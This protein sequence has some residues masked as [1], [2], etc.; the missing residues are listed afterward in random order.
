MGDPFAQVR[1]LQQG[2]SR[3]RH[4]PPLTARPSPELFLHVPGDSGALFPLAVKPPGKALIA[5]LVYE[6]LGLGGKVFNEARTVKVCTPSQSPAPSSLAMRHYTEATYKFKCHEFHLRAGFWFIPR[7]SHF[8]KAI[9]A[10]QGS[11]ELVSGL[12]HAFGERCPG[13]GEGPGLVAELAAVSPTTRAEP[14]S[15]W[16]SQLGRVRVWFCCLLSTA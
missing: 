10:S 3:C 6:P 7:V 16:R 9:P 13:E 5:V 4:S 15:A 14:L 2:S 11:C 12:S 1:V 8:L